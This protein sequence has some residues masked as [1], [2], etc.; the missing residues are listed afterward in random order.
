VVVVV[1]VEDAEA[2]AAVSSEFDVDEPAL[3]FAVTMI[4]T[5]RPT[6]AAVGT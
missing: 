2:M 6:S 3:F 5:E 1:V 4:R